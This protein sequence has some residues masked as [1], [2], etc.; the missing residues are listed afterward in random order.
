[1]H[2]LVYRVLVNLL[3]NAIKHSPRGGRVIINSSLIE[4]H[5]R[6]VVQDNGRGIPAEYHQKIF[7][8]FSQVQ[9]RQDGQKHS[10]GLGLTFCKLAVEAHGGRIGVDSEEGQ[11]SS[12]WFTLPI[13]PNFLVK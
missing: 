13:A 11:G 5:A 2:L 8:K 9:A 6:I 12:F 3:T 7:E 1:M 10:S 4:D